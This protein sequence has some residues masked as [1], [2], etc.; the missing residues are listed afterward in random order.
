VEY[1]KA[2]TR[3]DRCRFMMRVGAREAAH[4]DGGHEA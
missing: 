3:G 4:E 1:E 2:L